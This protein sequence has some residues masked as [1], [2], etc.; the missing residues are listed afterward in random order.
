MKINK[1]NAGREVIMNGISIK[2]P[3]SAKDRNPAQAYTLGIA[4]NE[5]IYTLA[6]LEAKLRNKPVSSVLEEILIERY[7]HLIDNNS[8]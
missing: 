3:P 4:T 5:R 1:P 6:N 2:L 7:K 8:I